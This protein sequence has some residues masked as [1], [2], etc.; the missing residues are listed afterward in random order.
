M[1]TGSARPATPRSDGGRRRATSSRASRASTRCGRWRGP[2]PGRA[3]RPTPPLTA[4][5]GEAK[6]SRVADVR[7]VARLLAVG[8]IQ[9]NADAF[10]AL[11]ERAGFAA[12]REETLAWT[13][14]PAT[15]L[16]LGDLLDG[17][18]EPGKVLTL[19]VSLAGQAEKAGGRVVLLRGNHELMLFSAL[20][21][22]APHA[23]DQW[24]ANGGL[25]TLARLAAARG[26]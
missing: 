10:A 13:A 24:F 17:G 21:E 23:V 8:D 20:R 2:A 3:D 14:G 1:S 4:E 11:L 22:G 9:S 19:V 6:A 18:Q 12:W 25:E 16:L 7:G 26:Y 5:R 15:L